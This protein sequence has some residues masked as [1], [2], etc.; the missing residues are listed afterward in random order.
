MSLGTAQNDGTVG[1]PKDYKKIKG[2]LIGV[3][4]GFLCEVV[5]STPARNRKGPGLRA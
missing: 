1:I 4:P 3:M 2:V 5:L